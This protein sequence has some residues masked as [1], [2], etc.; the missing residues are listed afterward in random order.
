VFTLP[1]DCYYRSLNEE[2]IARAGRS[3]YNFDHPSAFNFGSI[4]ETLRAIRE[5]AQTTPVPSYD[6]VSHSVRAPE[7]N[8]VIVSPSIVIFEGILAFHDP[9]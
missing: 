1:Q 2:E 9:V 8:S 3:D 6:Y 4:L 7:H 5:G